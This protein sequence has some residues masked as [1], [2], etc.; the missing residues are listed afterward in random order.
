MIAVIK[1]VIIIENF[2]D[3]K[4]MYFAII[5]TDVKDSLSLRMPVREKHLARLHEL[6]DA[7]RLLI[8]GPHPASDE[9]NPTT[10]AFT[11]S[12]VVAEFDSLAA[13]QSWADTDPYVAAGVYAEVMVKPYLKVLP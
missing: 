13:A 1:K 6:N 9:K 3:L 4:I 2:G 7:G 12:L 11:G 8:A 10:P 5:A